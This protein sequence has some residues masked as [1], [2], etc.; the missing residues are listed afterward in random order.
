MSLIPKVGRESFRI[1]FILLSITIFLW[2]GIFLHLIPIWWMVSSSFSSWWEIYKMP[3][4]LFPTHPNSIAWRFIFTRVALP[5]VQGAEFFGERALDFGSVF[6]YLKNSLIMTGGIMLF[7]IPINALVGYGLSKLSSP[8]WTKVMFLF[9]IGTMLMPGQSSIIP[10]FL[11]MKNFPFLTKNIPCIPFTD[12]VFPH[13]NFLER[14]WAVILPG[15]YNAFNV[16]LFKGFF[17][18]IPNEL[19]NAARLDGASELGIFRRIILPVSKPVFAVV[20]YFTFNSGWNMFMWPLIVIRKTQ[21]KL[22]LSVLLYR[23]QEL[24]L[25]VRAEDP[26]THKYLAQGLGVN[27]VMAI[28]LIQSIPT[29]IMFI[30]FREYLMKGI[31]LR[32]FK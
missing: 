13:I 16:L 31:K 20:A 9:F 18:T 8:K 6:I 3:P 10:R 12:I 1:R 7:G 15:V 25:N 29:F 2:L 26:D 5:H 24:M 14:Y 32:G 4:N 17:D 11:L 28:A 30:I 19:I 27:A 23:L 21:D 22:P